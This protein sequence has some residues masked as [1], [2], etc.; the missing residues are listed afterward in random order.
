MTPAH[1][2]MRIASAKAVAA[3]VR[4]VAVECCNQPAL[5]ARWLQAAQT[6]DEL[7]VLL[8]QA[9]YVAKL[10]HDTIVGAGA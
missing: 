1:V 8:D 6:I 2:A 10:N 5:A 4:A 9:T 3:N 7:V